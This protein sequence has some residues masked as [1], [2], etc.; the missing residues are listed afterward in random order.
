MALESLSLQ[1]GLREKRR[2]DLES[3]SKYA[4]P[5]NLLSEFLDFNIGHNAE[6]ERVKQQQQ[7]Q[8]EKLEM[9]PINIPTNNPT[10]F[11]SAK[12]DHYS[13]STGSTNTANDASRNLGPLDIGINTPLGGDI[14]NLQVNDNFF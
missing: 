9:Q 8:R 13:P 5:M 14:F 10:S 6:L 1:F 2:K 3:T 7:Q 12:Q 11:P 4:N